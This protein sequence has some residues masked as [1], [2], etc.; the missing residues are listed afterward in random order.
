VLGLIVEAVTGRPLAAELKRRI[1]DPAGL[2]STAFDTRPTIP[3]PHL[4]GYS[5]RTKS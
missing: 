2:G 3:G 5:R 4:H 1:F